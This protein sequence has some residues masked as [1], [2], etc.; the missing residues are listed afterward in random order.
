MKKWYENRRNEKMANIDDNEMTM[1]EMIRKTNEEGSNDINDVMIDSNNE[2][3]N[4]PWWNEKTN[5]IIL[6]K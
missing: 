5:D 1:T 3:A 6:M 2:M 4:E